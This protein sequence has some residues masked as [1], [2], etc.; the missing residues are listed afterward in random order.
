MT[1]VFAIVATGK[2]IEREFDSEF[3]ARKF[4]NKLKHSRRLQLISY[5]KH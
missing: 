3:K 4:M 5:W 1:V 2:R